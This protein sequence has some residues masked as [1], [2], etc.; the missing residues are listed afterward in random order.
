MDVSENQSVIITQE[1]VRN[2]CSQVMLN[3]TKLY[4]IYHYRLCVI[5][6]VQEIWDTRAA[7]SESDAKRAYQR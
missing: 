4:L 3:K 7:V 6:V 5:K 1:Y 2:I